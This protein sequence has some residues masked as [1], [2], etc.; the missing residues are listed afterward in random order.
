MNIGVTDV[1]GSRKVYRIKPLEDV[2]VRDW[3]AIATPAIPEDAVEGYQKTLELVSRHTTIPKKALNKMPAGDVRK[4]MDAMGLLLEDVV[5]VKEAAETAAPP[6]SFTHDGVEYLVPQSIETELL[7][8]PWESLDK[9]L[10]PK[11]ETDAECY[12]AILAVCCW[13]EG[14]AFDTSK[15][16]ARMELFMGLPVSVAFAVCGFFFDN[17]ET[18]RESMLRSGH[19]SRNLYRLKVEQALT[20]TLSSMAP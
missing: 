1:K 8:G 19:R 14:C 4:L 10:L 12:A 17:S 7:F 3:I 16:A 5:K 15:L 20:S 18:L 11:C 9:V 2:T 13:P 6:K